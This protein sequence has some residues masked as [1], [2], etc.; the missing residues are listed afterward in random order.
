MDKWSSGVSV[1][2]R[3][4]SPYALVSES[5]NKGILIINHL[6]SY[7]IIMQECVYGSDIICGCTRMHASVD[8]LM[9]R[10]KTRG[11]LQKIK[12]NNLLH[13]ILHSY[14]HHLAQFDFLTIFIT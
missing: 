6:P 11:V 8:N 9:M 5:H 13:L 4:R 3:V 1:S 10:G 2:V 7:P 12:N 14:V